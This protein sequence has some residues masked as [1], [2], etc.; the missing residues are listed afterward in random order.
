MT[1]YT[2]GVPGRTVFCRPQFR[3]AYG[4]CSVGP[5]IQ[6]FRARDRAIEPSPLPASADSRRWPQADRAHDIR[7]AAFIEGH[8]TQYADLNLAIFQALFANSPRVDVTGH[9]RFFVDLRG[10]KG[11]EQISAGTPDRFRAERV[12]ALH[13]AAICSGKFAAYAAASAAQDGPLIV[14]PAG[15]VSRAINL[16]RTQC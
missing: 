10:L 9:G 11:E 14:P 7:Q 16:R 5:W 3:T 8:P 4:F 15:G 2:R 1:T 6:P 12:K 13:Q